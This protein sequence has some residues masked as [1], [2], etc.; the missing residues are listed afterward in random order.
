M[1]G[2]EIL[3][4]IMASKSLSNAELAKRLN[5][6]IDTV[7]ETLKELDSDMDNLNI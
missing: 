3:K 5:V 1:R 6:S 2:R 4:E 7:Q